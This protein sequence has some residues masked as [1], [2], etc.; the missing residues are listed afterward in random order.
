MRLHSVTFIQV[1]LNHE[2]ANVVQEGLLITDSVKSKHT[3]RESGGLL[4]PWSLVGYTQSQ[5]YN[6]LSI[7][8][9]YVF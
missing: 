2:H 4:K 9:L 5:V 3:S 6:Y 8:I 7:G 1:M